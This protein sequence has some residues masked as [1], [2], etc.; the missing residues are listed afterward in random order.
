M[1]DV[2]AK[3]VISDFLLFG[4]VVF[5]GIHTTGN[6]RVQ[7]ILTTAAIVMMISLTVVGLVAIW[8]T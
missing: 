2:L 4:M 5:L 6:P 1:K 7:K 3:L 8:S